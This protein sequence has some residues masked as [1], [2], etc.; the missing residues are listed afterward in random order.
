MNAYR[1]KPQKFPWPP[2]FYGLAV[3]IALVLGRYAPLDSAAGHGWARWIAGSSLIVFAVCLDLW[4]VKTLLENHT[5]VLPHRS[6]TRLV[7]TGPFRF[8]R[9]PIYLG[10]TIMTVGL[11]L[12]M[13]NP[14]FFITGII[15]VA[16]TT[17]YAISREERHLLSR[18][19][20]EFERYCRSTTRWI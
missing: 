10:Y 4:A 11:G 8:T 5:T 1:E 19:G 2:I 18:F 13:Q 15:A 7:T 17:A 14:W 12:I 3:I 16:L 20:F 6:T 9:N